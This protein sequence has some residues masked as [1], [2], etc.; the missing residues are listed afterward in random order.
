MIKDIHVTTV[1]IS[2]SV[3]LVRFYWML[4][5]S[6]LLTMKPVKIIP[7]IN[8][9]I[10]LV[11]AIVLAVKMEQYPFIDHWLTAKVV[12]LLVYIVLGTIAL[13]RG[14]KKNTR[15]AAGFAAILVFAFMISIAVTKSPMGFL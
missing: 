4:I 2:I 8:D 6:R 9:T 3:F 13:K 11:S 5:G 1:L 15:I 7:H 10:L 12:L 14:K